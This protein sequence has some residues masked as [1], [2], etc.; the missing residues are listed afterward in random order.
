[1][2]TFCVLGGAE[3]IS[4]ELGTG[5]GAGVGLGVGTGVGLGVGTGVGL[6]VGTGVGLGGGK[7]IGPG[8]TNIGVPGSLAATGTFAASCVNCIGEQE[9]NKNML[10][11]TVTFFKTLPDLI[12]SSCSHCCVKQESVRTFGFTQRSEIVRFCDERTE[13]LSLKKM[14]KL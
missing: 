9:A 12:L 4:T 13:L 3:K 11:K 10:H 14:T 7:R 8:T 6:G 2:S 5:V 1:M